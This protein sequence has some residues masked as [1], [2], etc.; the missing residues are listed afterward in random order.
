MAQ[1]AC[2]EALGAESF[3]DEVLKLSNREP[4]TAPDSNR[5]EFVA[6]DEL[7]D[8]RTADCQDLSGA[9]DVHEKRSVISTV[10][11]YG[12]DVGRIGAGR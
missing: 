8:R 2:A 11:G 12:R 10:G 5:D 1:P 6:P 7:V 9:F 3:G 4:D